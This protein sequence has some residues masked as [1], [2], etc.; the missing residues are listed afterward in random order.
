M[1]AV[2]LVFQVFLV[3]GSLAAGTLVSGLLVPPR[4]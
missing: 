3:A 4:R 2:E 1:T